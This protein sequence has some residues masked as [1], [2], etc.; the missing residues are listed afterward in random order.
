MG[1]KTTIDRYEIVAELGKGGFATVYRAQDTKLN[2]EVALKII[3]GHHAQDQRFVQRFRQ[4]AQLAASLHNPRLITIYDFGEFEGQLFLAMRLV[5][6][7]TL[8]TYLKEN[9]PLGL[10][11]AL[12]FIDGRI[13]LALMFDALLAPGA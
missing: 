6:G 4:E 8:R 7:P 5:A 13:R 10:V 12:G 1:K 3:M 11:E 9:G 2:R